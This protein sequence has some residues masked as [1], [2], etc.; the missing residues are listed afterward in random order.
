VAR[1]EKSTLLLLFLLLVGSIFGSLLG[2]IINVPFL[3]YG[4]TI[5]FGPTTVDL[6]ALSLTLGL[7]L[8]LNLATIIGFILAFLLYTR[9]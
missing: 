8:K 2:E 5:G 1:V 9:L 3:H 4:R 7:S 6:A